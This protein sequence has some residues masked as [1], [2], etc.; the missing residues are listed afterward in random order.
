M[1]EAERVLERAIALQSEAEMA[2]PNTI[3][4]EMLG[5]IAAALQVDPADLRQALAE[6]LLRLDAEEPGWLDR[7]IGPEGVAAQAVVSG[8][9]AQVRAASTTGWPRTRASASGRK[10]STAP[11]GNGIRT[12]PL[13]PG[14]RST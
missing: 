13:P 3:D 1:A 8:R 10:R 14:W 11:A 2:T 12:S 7:L 9:A 4:T 6:E 5:R